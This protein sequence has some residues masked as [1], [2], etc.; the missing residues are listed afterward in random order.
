MIKNT[1]LPDFVD[2][3]PD[4]TQ[5]TSLWQDGM[6]WVRLE[7]DNTSL[8]TEFVAWAAIHDAENEKHF[9]TLP[10]WHFLTAGRIAY[11]VNRGAIPPAVTVAWFNK[12][13]DEL[14]AIPPEPDDV[15]DDNDV[16]SARDRKVI[17][18][19]NLYS[20]I[21]AIR[22]KFA[23]DKQLIDD[24][25]KERLKKVDPNRLMIRKLY[26][27]FKDSLTDAMQHK[28]DPYVES[29][30]D[31]L[32]LV[33]N[34]LA[35]ASG[36]ATVAAYN[37]AKVDRKAVKAAENVVYK[38]ID[39]D[40]DIASLNPAQVPGSTIAVI[41][42]TKDRKVFVYHATVGETLNIKGTKLINFDETRSFAKTLRKPKV[43]LQSL[44]SAVTTRRIEVVFDDINGK[45]HPVTGKVTKE[46]IIVK[47]FK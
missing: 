34:I 28:S 8:K 6:N 9:S 26:T 18:Y 42:N 14:R 12:K 33:V 19:V 31:Q 39:S 3:T 1:F 45:N 35:G 37:S 5:H 40:T 16:Y 7:I 43:I 23:D 11:L 44:R 2:M 17:E 36:N 4:H 32:V 46:M 20:Y 25:I 15:Q 24:K 13:V 27:H 21:D 47:V 10:V 38:T 30:I 29:T 41:Y 22:T